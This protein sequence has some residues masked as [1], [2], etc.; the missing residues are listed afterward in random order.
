[1]I[2]Y[3]LKTGPGRFHHNIKVYKYIDHSKFGVSVSR[4]G[5][6]KEALQ[7]EIISIVDA[8][9]GDHYEYLP[10]EKIERNSVE[11]LVRQIMTYSTTKKQDKTEWNEIHQKQVGKF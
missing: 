1:M 10:S 8:I 7:Q 9:Y 6:F 3:S 4:S 11:E 5:T 2:E